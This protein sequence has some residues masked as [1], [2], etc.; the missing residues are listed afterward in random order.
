MNIL[1]INVKKNHEKKKEG[2]EKKQMEILEQ[3]YTIT[4]L[5]IL[6]DRNYSKMERRQRKNQ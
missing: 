4:K 6:L 2:I 3:N 1:E 5:K